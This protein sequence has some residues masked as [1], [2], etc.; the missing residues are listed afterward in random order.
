MQELLQI[1]LQNY[2]AV[3]YPDMLLSLAEEGTAEAFIRGQVESISGEMDVMLA[4]GAPAYEVEVYC[5]D[6]LIGSLPPSKF[7]FICD[8]LEGEFIES[9][10]SFEQT[11]I[12]LFEVVNIIA[13]CELPDGF[14][15]EDRLLRYSVI[16]AIDSYLHHSQMAGH[17]V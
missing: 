6:V 14:D 12:L 10:K 11:N 9:Y 13:A 2:L 7:D 15:E 16:G 17:G 8:I 5:M 3:H 4:G 1:K